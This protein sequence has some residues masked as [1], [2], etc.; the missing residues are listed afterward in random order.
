MSS[1]TAALA[2]MN[3]FDGIFTVTCTH[4]LAM[5]SSGVP[6]AWSAQDVQGDL[7]ANYTDS[8]RKFLLII[9]RNIPSY[10][11]TLRSGVVKGIK[12]ACLRQSSSLFDRLERRV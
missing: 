8:K 4:Q 9:K 12:P 11:Y 1:V 2:A 6:H 5:T 7:R 10:F 3:R